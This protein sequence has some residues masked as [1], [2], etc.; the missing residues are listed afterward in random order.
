M[1]ITFQLSAF[2]DITEDLLLKI[3]E[4]QSPNAEV[5]SETLSAPHSAIETVIVTGLDTV[6]HRVKLIG[7]DT[8]IVYGEF[9]KQATIDLVTFT[10]P[11]KFTIGDGQ[12]GTPVA[13][14]SSYQNDLLI[15]LTA[16]EDFIYNRT[17]YGN[18]I[19]GLTY[20]FNSG[21]GTIQLMAGD[22]WNG[23]PAPDQVWITFTP[24]SVTQTV[25]DSVVGKLFGGFVDVSGSQNYIPSHL[26]KL[27]RL[28]PSSSYNF[29]G[30]IPVGYNHSF[31]QVGSGSATINF[32]NAPLLWNGGT[33]TSLSMPQGS[34]A[35]FTFDGTNW[36]CTNYTGSVGVT[37]FARIDGAGSAT[38]GNPATDQLYTISLVTPQPDADY[39][40][41]CTLRGQS[42]DFSLDNDV[43][44]VTRERTTNSFKIALREYANADQSLVLDYILIRNN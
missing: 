21:T 7:A 10:K 14:T 35:A 16:D 11:Q 43:S 30:S 22:Q 13:G 28:T 5:H 20:T 33:V 8:D 4:E 17:G 18:N 41:I 44:F 40:P 12:P 19:L 42:T 26:R 9:V 6:T 34:T 15:G 32:N 2:V 37:A 39:L 29:T 31:N 23:D 25:N 38:I 1:N 3:Y 24:K 27:I 36:N